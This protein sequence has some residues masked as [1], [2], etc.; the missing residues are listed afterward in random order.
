MYT[1]KPKRVIINKVNSITENNYEIDE[2]KKINNKH[3][4]KGASR[5]RRRKRDPVPGGI[6]RP[7]CSWGIQIQGPGPPD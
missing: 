7:P 4:G 2:S 3:T 6:T 1:N 5:R